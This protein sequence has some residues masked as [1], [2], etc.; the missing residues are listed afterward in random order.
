MS[1]S[2]NLLG[3]GSHQETVIKTVYMYDVQLEDQEKQ[4]VMQ[5]V[6]VISVH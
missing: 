6:T 4:D 1:A 5:I 2:V 3:Y